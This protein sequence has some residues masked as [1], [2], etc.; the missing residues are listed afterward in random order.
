VDAN[1][2]LS[3]QMNLIEIPRGEKTF[4]EV[5]FKIEDSGFLGLGGA[6]GEPPDGGEDRGVSQLGKAAVKS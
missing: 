4:K 1:A 3:G 5:T 2:W 6:P